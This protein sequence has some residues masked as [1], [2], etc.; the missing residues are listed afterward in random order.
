[1]FEKT[2]PAIILLDC[3]GMLAAVKFDDELSRIA[4]EIDNVGWDRMLPA[5]LPPGDAPVSQQKPKQRFGIG[6]VSAQAAGE[7]PEIIRQF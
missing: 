7:P 2:C 3:F 6:P 4:I 1:V 5:E